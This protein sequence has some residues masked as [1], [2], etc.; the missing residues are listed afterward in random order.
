MAHVSCLQGRSML[1]TGAPAAESWLGVQV[2][3]GKGVCPRTRPPSVAWTTL[4]LPLVCSCS[5]PGRMVMDSALHS[6]LL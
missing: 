3:E 2:L 4:G 1:G 6:R 5:I